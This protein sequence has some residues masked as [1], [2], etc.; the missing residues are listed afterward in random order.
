MLTLPID[1]TTAQTSMPR[2]GGSVTFGEHVA[3]EILEELIELVRGAKRPLILAGSGVRGDG[4]PARLRTVAERF[5]CPVATTP[6]AKGVFP[7]D[8]PLALGVLGLGGHPSARKY[9]DSDVDVVIAIGTSLGDMSTDGF[10]PQLQGTRALVHI[11]IDA[12]QIGKS[13]TPTHAVV[14]SAAELLGGLAD[15]LDGS[16]PKPGVYGVERHVL[17]ASLRTDKVGAA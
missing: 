9:L 15:M 11:D 6:K 4:A 5:G 2:V 14:A 16:V 13:Y 17:P 12:R 1:V 10:A 3:P 8:H 7:E